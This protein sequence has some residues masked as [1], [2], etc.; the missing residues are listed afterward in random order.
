MKF[1]LFFSVYFF[2]QSNFPFI[3]ADLPIH[4]LKSQTHGVWKFEFSEPKISPDHLKNTCGHNTP[5]REKTSFKALENS[6]AP[7]FT[8]SLRLWPNG[9]VE[10]LDSTH[11]STARFKS[12]R[13]KVTTNTTQC[14][15]GLSSAW[16]MVYDE[17]F[18]IRY[19]NMNMFTFSSYFPVNSRYKSNCAKTC[20]GWYRNTKTKEMGCFR[21]ER[22]D[23]DSHDDYINDQ[24]EQLNVVEGV[25]EE[26]KPKM[27]FKSKK[28]PRFKSLSKN[29]FGEKLLLSSNFKE[30]FKV[31]NRINSISNNLWEA[32]VYSSFQGLSIQELNQ[33]AGRTRHKEKIVN[34]NDNSKIKYK[35]TKKVDVSDLPT[36]FSWEKY[37]GEPGQQSSCG[38]CYAIST[39][40]ML[41]A[42]LKIR[43]QLNVKLSVNFAVEC[44]YYN[45]GCDG[46]YSF[47]L[48]RFAEE[49]FLIDENCNFT[50]DS[51]EVCEYKCVDPHRVYKVKDYWYIGGSYGE[52]NERNI[53]EEIKKNGPVVL[54]FEPD[55]TFML[56]KRGIYDSI[57]VKSWMNIDE[58]KPEWYKVDHSVVCYGWGEEN[59]QKY[60]LLM[61]SWGKNWGENGHF[62]MKRGE[63]LLGIEFIGESA[64]PYSVKKKY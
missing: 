5:D 49:S 33:M 47:L 8:M 4:C 58:K 41:E 32:D 25:V 43:E 23:V 24:T 3:F 57:K 50:K 1:Y 55:Y 35:K 54:S 62:K 16:T 52:T 27:I 9:C 56:Y 10:H 36:S 39:I 22:T 11:T 12:N 61:N 60:W 7:S 42:R 30:H 64:L 31:V 19:R 48:S 34:T 20:V 6:F 13:I 21:G 63:D 45:Q 44:S 15:S 26:K 59:G 51:N 2:L 46:G 28:T 53:M 14:S 37:L 18:E 38:S 40:K 17:G 29:K